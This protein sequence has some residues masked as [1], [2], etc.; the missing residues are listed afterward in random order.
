[1]LANQGLSRMAATQVLHEE[2]EMR[3]TIEMLFGSGLSNAAGLAWLKVGSSSA[4]GGYDTYV[5]PA[6]IR[7]DG[8]SVK[9]WHMHDFKIAQA[10]AD[11]IYWSSKN[12]V[13]YDCANARR[14]TLYF[15]WNAERMGAGEVIHRMDEPSEWRPVV[16]GSIA[17]ILCRFACRKR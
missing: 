17:E 6:A 9:M 13:E 2:G 15:S 1:M 4:V 3:N 10:A 8:D 7:R 12:M 11:K 5:D 14:R 16:P